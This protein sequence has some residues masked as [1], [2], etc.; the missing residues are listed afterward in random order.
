MNQNGT[1]VEYPTV[2]LGGTKYE[3]KFTRATLY[4]LD[5]A[6]IVFNPQVVRST[7]SLKFST[8]VDTLKLCIAFEGTAEELAELSFDKRDEILVVL[9]DAWGKVVLPSLQTRAA[10]IAANKQAANKDVM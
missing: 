7:A 1:G 5:K 10:A 2:E 3:V 4:Q 9:V 8:I 6:G